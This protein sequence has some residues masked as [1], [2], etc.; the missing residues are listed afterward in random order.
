MR[1]EA[2]EEIPWNPTL[3]RANQIDGRLL[4]ASGQPVGGRYVTALSGDARVQTATDSLGSFA[5]L[6]PEGVPQRVTVTSSPTPLATIE[7]ERDGVLPGTHLELVLP[8]ARD[9]LAT[10]FGTFVD[11][12][13]RAGEQELL[14]VQLRALVELE[15]QA[16]ILDGAFT[17]EEVTPGL[18]TLVV[19]AGRLPIYT[20]EPIDVGPSERIDVGRI[21]TA[22]PGSLV[23][24]VETSS[25]VER[26]LDSV[27]VVAVPDHALGFYPLTVV[28][29]QL[30]STELPPGTYQLMSM[31][32]ECVLVASMFEVSAA[33]ETRLSARL[34]P[35]VLREFAV[36]LPNEGERQLRITIDGDD[37]RVFD[38]T[39][40]VAENGQTFP[41]GR[42]LTPGAWTLRFEADT[43]HSVV[44][45]L[46]VTAALEPA[47]Q[48][49]L[50]LDAP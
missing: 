7:V 46:V 5:L 32:T 29:D 28:G 42:A 9:D 48:E 2:G 1:A 38:V 11:E 34:E 6:V 50:V 10:V 3:D 17:L 24:G 39:A 45:E 47:E 19:F 27:Q 15:A 4:D 22:V 16:E 35:A 8:P 33:T 25:G 14:V 31:E 30:E 40:P 37:G 49:T 20:S 18:Y 12:G 43:G 26:P 13:G 44:R 41:F 23:V 21:A 36:V